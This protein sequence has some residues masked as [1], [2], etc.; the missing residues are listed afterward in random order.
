MV[1]FIIKI[2][3][4]GCSYIISSSLVCLYNTHRNK[5]Y[6]N[7][8]WTRQL[9]L[10]YSME[11]NPSWDANWFSTSQEIP[12][13]LWKPKVRYRIHKSLP[14]VHILNQTN[15][16]HATHHTSWRL[17]SKLFSHLYLGLPSG[18]FA[19]GFPTNPLCTSLLH[20]RA[21]CPTHLL[22]DF[23]IQTIFSEQSRS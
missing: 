19:S 4:N 17:I 10:S 18:R 23:I 15:P 5:F 8:H 2:F 7:T 22:L 6:N 12:S 14:P 20:V 3:Y 11:Q 21:T 1:G 16:V 9:L 13:F